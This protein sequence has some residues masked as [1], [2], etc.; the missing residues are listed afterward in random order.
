M[1]GWMDGCN[2]KIV[3]MI[4]VFTNTSACVAIHGCR[5][6]QGP[7]LLYS[8]SRIA[9][10]KK[11]ATVLQEAGNLILVQVLNSLRESQMLVNQSRCIPDTACNRRG[12]S[13][14]ACGS[15]PVWGYR[16][17]HQSCRQMATDSMSI[18]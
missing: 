4:T 15:S 13:A 12:R 8:S 17:C 5:D 3:P 2:S 10:L 9:R 14:E 18:P 6:L 7:A 1:D 16:L 11:A